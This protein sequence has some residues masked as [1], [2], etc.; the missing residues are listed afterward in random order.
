M[1]CNVSSVGETFP[2][3]LRRANVFLFRLLFFFFRYTRVSFRNGK[4]SFADF[5]KSFGARTDS[6]ALRRGFAVHKTAGGMAAEKN[7]RINQRSSNAANVVGR[8]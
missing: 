2:V 7:K 5:L 3:S 8:K 4:H 6:S 1:R